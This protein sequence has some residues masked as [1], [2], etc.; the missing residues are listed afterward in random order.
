MATRPEFR[1]LLDQCEEMQLSHLRP[2]VERM[3]EN[4][5]VALLDFAEKAENNMAQTLFFDAMNEARKK[6]NA[7]AQQLFREI[8]RS[9]SEFPIRPEDHPDQGG[10]ASTMESLSLVDNEEMETTVAT[11]NA[12]AKL[13]SRIMEQIFALKQRLAVINGG[14]TIEE[15]EIPGGP[16]WLAAAYRHAVAQLELENKVK[17]VFIALFDKYVLSQIDPMFDEFN[18]RLIEAGILPNLRYEVRKQPG[19]V[20]IVEKEVTG[21]PD[22]YEP[23][24]PVDTREPMTDQSPSELG[25]ELFGRICE[26]MAGRRGGRPAAGGAANVTPIRPGG[27]SRPGA[28]PATGQGD[29]APATAGSGGGSGPTG[30]GY[31]AAGA[32]TGAAGATSQPLVG[33]IS[34]LQSRIQSDTSALSSTEFI[35]N[36]E[37]DTNLIERL[38]HT[39]EEEREKIFHGIDRR[40]LPDA[41]NDV[42]ELVGMMFEYM[43]RD[44]NLPNVVKALLSRLHT[45]LLKVAVVNKSFFTEADHPARRLLDNMTAAGIRWVDESEADRG[46]FPKMKAIVDR[47]L[48]E[49]KEDAGIFEEVLEE[50]D[51]AVE[52]L[53]RRAQ[54]VEKRT[55]EAANGQEKLQAA[56]HQARNE[57]LRQLEGRTVAKSASEFLQRIWA[58]KLTFILLRENE[59]VESDAWHSAAASIGRIIDSVTPPAND[60]E[61]KRR[62]QALAELQDSLREQTQSMQQPDKEKLLGALFKSQKLVLEG[63]TEKVAVTTAPEAAPKPQTADAGQQDSALSPEQEAMLEKLESV[64]FGTWFEFTRPGEERRRAKLS[65]RSTITEKYMFVDQMGVK[66]S[67]IAMHDLANSMLDGSVRIIDNARKPFVERALNAIHRMLDHSLAETAHA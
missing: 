21:E 23:E 62:R 39:L 37:I 43:L 63:Q 49:Y 6:H 15:A 53:N 8:K 65:W 5:D 58:D 22:S 17:L 20:E 35:E 54:V 4:A 12:A 2:L 9:F 52:E 67:V 3:F 16:T 40:Q 57:I 61:R 7:I 26:L 13:S 11:F 19:S 55:M 64:P 66:A 59:G 28:P 48:L 10:E 18:R 14:A 44:E 36:I 34:S 1:K 51:K 42:I 45:P 56:R 32:G 25:D 41:D 33:Q 30:S 38:Q 47:L 60:G 29:P 27:G 50:F 31:A 46:I 24:S